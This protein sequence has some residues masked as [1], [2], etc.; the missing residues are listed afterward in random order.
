VSKGEQPR[1]AQVQGQEEKVQEEGSWTWEE[2]TGSKEDEE[3]ERH[4]DRLRGHVFKP[5]DEDEVDDKKK[6]NLGK[7]LNGLCVTGLSLKDDFCGI[8]GSD[9]D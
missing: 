8:E 4:Q 9:G 3:I 5:S 2:D 1:Q 7:Y 6:K